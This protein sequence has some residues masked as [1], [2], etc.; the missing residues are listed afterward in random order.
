M[1][2]NSSGCIAGPGGAQPWHHR[3]SVWWRRQVPPLSTP[4]NEAVAFMRL[5]V[6]WV[7]PCSNS[8]DAV[9]AAYEVLRDALDILLSPTTTFVIS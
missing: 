5:S 3:V 6:E 9:P 4:R 2:P 8:D 1:R 7:T